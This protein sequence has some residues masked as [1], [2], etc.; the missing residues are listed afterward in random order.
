MRLMGWL[1]H[2][3]A[4]REFDRLADLFT[5]F[6]ARPRTTRSVLWEPYIGVY[7]EHI[8]SIQQQSLDDTAVSAC[9]AVEYLVAADLLFDPQLYYPPFIYSL[10]RLEVG[11]YYGRAGSTGVWSMVALLK[12]GVA[13]ANGH[14]I[15]N[16][17][18][19][20][21]ESWGLKIPEQL[22]MERAV[23]PVGSISRLT[24]VSEIRAALLC[25][26]PVTIASNRGFQM[27]PANYRG[28]HVF[29]P[30]LEWPHQ[31]TLLGWMDDPFPAAYRL[32][33]WGPNVH[34]Q[35][36]NGEP[37]GG[38]WNLAEDLESELRIFNCEIFT[39]SPAENP[40]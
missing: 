15:P 27:Q 24:S 18:A 4:E 20:E 21:A 38:A 13:P 35:P 6:T 36:L 10:A 33:T 11:Q 30:E 22:V 8:R 3:I 2:E 37:P 5:P 19:T 28:H 32:N 7:G 39:I 31:M 14:K 9:Q 26:R 29:K 34:G 16:Y 12:Y 25:R 17:T 40:P 23:R 1:G